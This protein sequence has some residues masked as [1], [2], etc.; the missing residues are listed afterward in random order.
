MPTQDYVD[1]KEIILEDQR[2][3]APELLAK[4]VSV[5]EN[6]RRQCHYNQKWLSLPE[7]SLYLLGDAPS[8]LLH[9]S[10]FFPLYKHK[11][12]IIDNE[13]F[14]EQ[15]KPWFLKDLKYLIVILRQALWQHLG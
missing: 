13:E 6:V 4:L 8:W 15:E 2:V 5:S 12:K 10:I 1:G 7:Q 14:Y 9:V 11:L 3:H